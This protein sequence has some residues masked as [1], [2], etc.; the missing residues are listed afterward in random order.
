MMHHKPAAPQQVAKR[1]GDTLPL[2]EVLRS[3]V[4][5]TL[6]SRRGVYSVLTALDQALY[7]GYRF[8]G[9]RFVGGG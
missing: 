1:F 2:A 5:R 3:A 8:V 9:Y 6:R 4:R 7:D